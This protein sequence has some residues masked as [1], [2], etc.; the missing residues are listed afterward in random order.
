MDQPDHEQE[1]QMNAFNSDE[2]SVRPK[3][4]K[5]LREA[6]ADLSNIITPDF[7]RD[8][9]GIL[10][11]LKFGS[12][13]MEEFIQRYM[14]ALCVFDPLQGFVP[15][16]INMGSRN[17]MRDCMAPLITLGEITGTSFLVV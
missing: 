13:E 5:Q 8:T 4:T 17:A 7:S 10:R 11:R 2:D 15:P 14:P 3:L 16:N 6:G 9:D 12:S 1:P